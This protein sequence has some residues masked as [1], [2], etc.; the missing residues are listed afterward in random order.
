VYH[1]NLIQK[2]RRYGLDEKTLRW[3]EGWLNNRAESVAG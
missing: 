2:L 1:R 3:I